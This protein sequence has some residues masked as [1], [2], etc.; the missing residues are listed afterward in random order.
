MLLSDESMSLSSSIASVP[1]RTKKYED[2]CCGSIRSYWYVCRG[3]Y[4]QYKKG[5]RKNSLVLHLREIRHVFSAWIQPYTNICIFLCLCE[6]LI[7]RIMHKYLR[8]QIFTYSV[9]PNCWTGP[10]FGPLVFYITSSVLKKRKLAS[11]VACEQYPSSNCDFCLLYLIH[12][13]LAVAGVGSLLL[14]T[15]LC[16][17]LST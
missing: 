7:L 17:L 2:F 10:F 16:F 12:I 15:V 14:R 13:I 6:T 8:A 4:P 5:V 3:T 1:W 11:A 9:N